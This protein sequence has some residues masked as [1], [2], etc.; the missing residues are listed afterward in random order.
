MVMKMVKGKDVVKSTPSVEDLLMTV[1]FGVE[2]SEVLTR[3]KKIS[4][5]YKKISVSG[6]VVTACEACID[7]F[8]KEIPN[9]RR[10]K[11]NGVDVDV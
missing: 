3:M 1:Y 11:L 9:K 2:H 5:E 10:F 4:S 6:M 7:T 8:E